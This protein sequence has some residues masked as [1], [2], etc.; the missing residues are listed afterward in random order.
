MSVPRALLR[1]SIGHHSELLEEKTPQGHTHR[2][3]VFL[4]AVGPN[5]FKDRSFVK[6]VVF[7]LHPDF[8]NPR[9]V[10]REPPFEVTETG[11][12]G[13]SIPVTVS[14]S[15]ISKVYNLHYDMNLSYEKYDQRTV[16]QILEFKQPS[17]SF[18]DLIM[19][20]GGVAKKS[21]RIKARKHTES[22]NSVEANETRK[23]SPPE[24]DM[25][26]CTA[27]GSEEDV[28]KELS[29]LKSSNESDIIKRRKNS[30]S[31]SSTLSETS[32]TAHHCMSK[33]LKIPSPVRSSDRNSVNTE[34]LKARHHEEN[35]DSP[36][37]K[38]T[39]EEVNLDQLL[40]LQ[41]ELMTLSDNEK[42]IVAAEVLISSHND[43]LQISEDNLVFDLCSLNSSL[44]SRLS[45]ICGK[46]K[47]C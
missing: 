18:Y 14:F 8:P 38:K 47:S 29:V 28:M 25:V 24:S 37:P 5:Q 1:L 22:S 26:I 21:D 31:R 10:V 32:H 4:R 12:A 27:G 23:G 3:T 42:I 17:Q 43:S 2:W 11:Y 45:E 20:Y 44:V 46:S 19:Q 39:R 41:R 7:Q 40:R 13:F 30:I 9:R 16:E 6:K 15:G 33:A 34:K 36:E 35:H